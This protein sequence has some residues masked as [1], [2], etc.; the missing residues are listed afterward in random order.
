M[1]NR[2]P[3]ASP[4]AVTWFT[5]V[6][7]S[8]KG[9][10]ATF[11]PT[12]ASARPGKPRTR[13]PRFRSRQGLIGRT[14]KNID[15]L[16]RYWFEERKGVRLKQ[17]RAREQAVLPFAGLKCPLPDGRGSDLANGFG[18]ESMTVG[19]G[20][21]AIRSGFADRPARAAAVP[22]IFAPRSS[23]FPCVAS[24]RS[25]PPD[26]AGTLARPENMSALT[27]KTDR[28]RVENDQKSFKTDRKTSKN[29]QKTLKIDR[30]TASVIR[31]PQPSDSQN[32][33]V[34]PTNIAPSASATTWHTTKNRTRKNHCCK[35]PLQEL[36]PPKSP[37]GNAWPRITAAPCHAAGATPLPPLHTWVH[38]RRRRRG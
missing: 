22:A 4:F 25:G 14:H 13:Q 5:F 36:F 30:K 6:F 32:A 3:T 27:L 34:F 12:T 1:S 35:C 9:S 7:G 20:E 28:N 19:T 17:S 31:R 2:A 37:I 16:A 26:R 18:D 29:D 24:Y 15:R 11:A 8:K 33:L 21:S 23:I 10:S 38:P